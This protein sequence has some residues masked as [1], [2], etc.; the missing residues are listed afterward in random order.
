MGFE[1]HSHIISA[2]TNSKR[3]LILMECLNHFNNLALLT[4]RHA[5][6]NNNTHLV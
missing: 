1:D 4:G 6:R 2:I 5:A 3:R